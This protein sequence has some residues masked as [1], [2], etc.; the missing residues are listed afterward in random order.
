[1]TSLSIVNCRVFD[2][3]NDGTVAGPIHIDGGRVVAVGG[4]AP[5][6]D[7]VIDAEGGTV[8]PGLID[9]HFHAYCTH[10]DMLTV[11]T[12]SRTYLGLAAARRLTSALRRGFT[13]VRDPA[14]GDA[15]LGRAIH[16]RLFLSPNYLWTGPALSQ[17]GGHG[18]PRRPGAWSG[19]LPDPVMSEVVDGADAL[20]AAV[21][22]RIAEGAHAIKLMASGGVDSAA[23]A[24]PEYSPDEMVA[25]VTEARRLGSYV[26]AHA[27]SPSAIRQSVECGV[28]CIEHANLLD[29]QT[30]ALMREKSVD[31]VPTLIVYDAM[32]RRS[33]E[34]GITPR[35]ALR[36]S[37]FVSLG[38]QAIGT[39]RSAG[40]RI[41]FGTD[42]PGGLEDEQLAGLRLHAEV[43]GV[44]E[45]LR[46]ATS[47]NADI[48]GETERG[49]IREGAIADL[50]VLEGDPFENHEVLWGQAGRRVVLAGEPVV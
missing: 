4:H 2:G 25:A 42:L 33:E 34:A 44:Y 48:L 21:R 46:S 20:R 27:Y 3:E 26:T 14:G 45:T 36:C 39:A 47:V 24:V 22:S 5:T 28:R 38:R 23:H 19:D 41:G 10:V 18:D 37:E 8:I 13:T 7:H 12:T 40:L 35:T 30:A 29:A 15:G 32:S 31:L 16:E 11:E 6:A 49:R 17:T 50:V 9:A 43:L 1:M